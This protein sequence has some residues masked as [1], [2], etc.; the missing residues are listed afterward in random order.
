LVTLALL[1]GLAWVARWALVRWIEGPRPTAPGRPWPPI[2]TPP[3]EP[4]PADTAAAAPD[5]DLAAGL[6]PGP[7]LVPG[8]DRA[9]SVGTRPEPGTDADPAGATDPS[10]IRYRVAGEPSWLAPDEAGTCPP[11]HPVKAK[12]ST[13][14]YR[15]P[16]SPAYDRAMPDRCYASP[17]AAEADGFTRAKR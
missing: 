15:V 1:C 4:S 7:E 2:W 14:L 17:E 10:P 13:R 12:R 9:T 3:D 6:A 16:G 8:A 5:V 11:T